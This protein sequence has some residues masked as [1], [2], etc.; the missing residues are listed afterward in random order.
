MVR[1]L[2]LVTGNNRLSRRLLSSLLSIPSQSHRRNTKVFPLQ[3]HASCPGR[4]RLSPLHPFAP[5][6]SSLLFPPK[7]MTLTTTTRVATGGVKAVAIHSA[8]KFLCVD[9]IQRALELLPC[10]HKVSE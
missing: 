5:A 6:A 9:N 10:Q 2:P 8:R 7:Q 4:R 3:L 1:F